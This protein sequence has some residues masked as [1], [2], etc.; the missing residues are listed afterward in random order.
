M[1]HPS[2]TKKIYRAIVQDPVNIALWE[3]WSKIYNFH[4]EYQGQKGPVPA[5]LF[6]EVNKEK[7]DE[8]A[9]SLWPQR[10][11]YYNLRVMY[12]DD[13]ISFVSEMQNSP[14]DPR[15]R[16]FNIDAFH[17]WNKLYRTYEELVKAFPEIKFYAACDPSL[18]TPGRYT[19]KLWIDKTDNFLV[20][21]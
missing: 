11:D 17:Y 15:T 14:F 1:K 5:R 6:Y 10:W 4:K 13:P 9:V 12:E 20:L 18:G 3:E 21:K 2:W 16:T 19:Q 7:M 8:G